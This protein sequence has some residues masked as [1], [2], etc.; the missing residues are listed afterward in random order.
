MKSELQ[1]VLHRLPLK[2]VSESQEPEELTDT[3]AQPASDLVG[4]DNS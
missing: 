2:W 3:D 4:T 1:V